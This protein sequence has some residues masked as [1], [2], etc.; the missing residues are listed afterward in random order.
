MTG[1]TSPTPSYSERRTQEWEAE[2]SE[3]MYAPDDYETPEAYVTAVNNACIQMLMASPD[4]EG[5]IS[6][7]HTL[8]GWVIPKE[9]RESTIQTYREWRRKND[10]VLFKDG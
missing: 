6:R 7:Y 4:R 8:F 10:A 3:R 2:A 5:G 9:L 1:T